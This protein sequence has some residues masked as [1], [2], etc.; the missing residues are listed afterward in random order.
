MADAGALCRYGPVLCFVF[1]SWSGLRLVAQIRQVGL[2]PQ[3]A[4]D[5]GVEAV[6][7]HAGGQDGIDLAAATI[8]L[9]EDWR[10]G[11]R[12]VQPADPAVLR[13][14]PAFDQSPALQAVDEAADGDRLDLEQ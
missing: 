7:S 5:G 4:V 8:D 11:R 12:Q 14:G 9:L 2:H 6:G 10:G 13:V 1:R 3:Q